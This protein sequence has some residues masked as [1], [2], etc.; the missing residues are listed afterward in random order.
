MTPTI[1]LKII[2]SADDANNY[3]VILLN[4]Q[5]GQTVQCDVPK[6]EFNIDPD[7]LST[8]LN[9]T[10][11]S[12]D[13]QKIGKKLYDNIHR[14]D[15]AAEWDNFKANNQKFRIYFDV[16]P[17]EIAALPWELINDGA[18]RLAVKPNQT[19]IRRYKPNGPIAVLPPESP[20]LPLRILIVVGAEMNDLSVLAP[21]EIRQ[22]KYDIR[23]NLN[24]VHRII[25]LEVLVRPTLEGLK[26][27]YIAFKPDIFHF[28]GHGGLDPAGN[29]ML[30]LNSL[31]DNDGSSTITMWSS[32]TILLNFENWEWLPRFVFI[33]AC[34]SNFAL[35]AKEMIDQ[36]W[37]V[38]KTFRELN[39]PAV[40]TM[41]AD[42]KGTVA[43]IFSGALYKSLAELNTLDKA[44]V[45]ARETVIS[46]VEG[47]VNTRD[48]A[49]P[50]I[51]FAVSPDEVF[52]IQPPVPPNVLQNIIQ[53]PEFK[54][55]DFFSA[56]VSERRELIQSFYPLPPASPDRN[57]IIIKGKKKTGKSWLAKFCLQVCALLDHEVRYVEVGGINTKTC[58][59]ILLHITCGDP[60]NAASSLIYQPLEKSAFEDFYWSLKHRLMQKEPSER[61]NN[62][63]K[64]ENING[65]YHLDNEPV[66][67]PAQA[68]PTLFEETFSSFLEALKQSAGQQRPLIIAL[69]NFAGIREQEITDYLIPMLIKP[70]V[71]GNLI[72][73]AAGE[74]SSRVKFIMVVDNDEF[75]KFHLDAI[76]GNILNVVL[77]PFNQNN[78][79]SFFEEFLYYALPDSPSA[80]FQKLIE[81]IKPAFKAKQEFF[82]EMVKFIL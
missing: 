75:N 18:R 68:S 77:E 11:I 1:V 8:M 9:N 24:F 30:V 47:E 16:E 46:R 64:V 15:V 44:V 59:D 27:V 79:Y 72:N 52:S 57:L 31:N 3:S 45:S 66:G 22:I 35:S 43:G 54:E 36:A 4:E 48:W 82:P 80:D 29:G 67:L 10:G 70:V 28:I 73:K 74:T 19:F 21:E 34:R 26:K 32:D 17:P 33:N 60:K 23:N 62:T 65:I 49:T 56:R 50:V 6:S 69:D 63:V 42:I 2:Q 14:G 51:T 12:P 76:F 55:I 41:Q 37:S 53:C 7:P 38:G 58:L 13:F 71:N 39:I 20:T 78:F 5:T 81:G 25:D 61:G 40:L